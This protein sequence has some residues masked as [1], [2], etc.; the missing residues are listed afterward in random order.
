MFLISCNNKINNPVEKDLTI[1]QL[2]QTKKAYYNS[3][4]E[5]YLENSFSSDTSEYFYGVIIEPNKKYRILLYGFYLQDVDFSLND[6][7]TNLI[8]NGE[9]ADVGLTSK[10]LI[11]EAT[12]ADTLIISLSSD[13][14]DNFGKTFYLA[15]EEIGTYELE[16][17]NKTW[18]C[19]GDWTVDDKDKLIFKGYG[20][21]FSKWIMLKDQNLNQFTA[22]IEFDAV[23]TTLETFI[24][25]SFSSSTE[26]FDMINLPQTGRQ[27]KISGNNNWEFWTINMN[28]GIGRETGTFANTIQAGTNSIKIKNLSTISCFVN[29]S[30]AYQPSDCN[31]GFNEFYI[32]IEDKDV[33]EFTFTKF[34]IAE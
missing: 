9:Q 13:N 32:T 28:K 3:Q 17:Q 29:D 10:Y 15:F 30:L 22:E 31:T 26:I 16:W 7:D 12:K 34:E 6:I 11:Y 8:A 33:N 23:S 4:N 19:D 24:G 27:F 25:Y 21:G 5:R 14:N 18:I 20:S 1:L 2:D